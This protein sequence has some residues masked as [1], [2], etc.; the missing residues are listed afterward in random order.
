M[1]LTS[2]GLARN[3]DDIQTI[4]SH[5]PN[6]LRAFTETGDRAFRTFARNRARADLENHPAQ[7][8]Q[9]RLPGVLEQLEVPHERAVGQRQAATDRLL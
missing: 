2:L 5:G 9:K 1:A 7:H 4:R 6:C 8:A 3:L